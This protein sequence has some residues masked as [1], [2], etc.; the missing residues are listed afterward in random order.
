ME[1][2]VA[3]TVAAATTGRAV[4]AAVAARFSDPRVDKI[5]VVKQILPKMFSLQNILIPFHYEG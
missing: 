5:S 4:E 1:A 3:A 2:A